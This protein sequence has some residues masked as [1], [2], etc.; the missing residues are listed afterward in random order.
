MWRVGNLRINGG[1]MDIVVTNN[2]LVIAQYEGKYCVDYIET[3]LLGILTT[4]RD[5]I[6]KGHRLLTHPLMGSVKPNESPYKSVVISSTTE[7]ADVQSVTIIGESILAAKK[8]PP[9]EIPEQ[10]LND[11]QIVDL[12]LIRSALK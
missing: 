4:V 7:G 9:K 3:D 1:G 8:F 2:P 6:H 10:Y 5:L 12:S 11:L